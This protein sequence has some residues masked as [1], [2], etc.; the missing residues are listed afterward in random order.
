MADRA[1]P[2]VVQPSLVEQSRYAERKR[3]RGL[4][5][6]R[7]GGQV[8]WRGDLLSGDGSQADDPAAL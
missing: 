5:L 4:G 7:V 1:A 6:H 8:G 3:G 2:A